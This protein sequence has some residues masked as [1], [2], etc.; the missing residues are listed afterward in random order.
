MSDRLSRRRFLGTV[1]ATGAGAA[2][3]ATAKAAPS[4]PPAGTGRQRVQKI[5]T[6][7]E[8]CFWRCGVLASV[9]RR[10]GRPA[11]GQPR[12]PAHPGAALRPRQRG[13]EPALRPRPARSTR[14][15][16]P[17]S[18][19]RASSSA[20]AGTRRSTSSPTSSTAHQGGARPRGGG[21]LPARH[22][23]PLLRHPDEGLRHAQQRRALVRAVPRPARRRLH[24]HLR[25][26][27]RLARAARPRRVE[28]HRP[29]RQPPRRE[30][31]HLADHAV[32]R[33]PRRA[34]RS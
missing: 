28:A 33:R 30:R 31:L 23:L 11:R 29:H 27:S 22:R 14:C 8:M 3:A 4:V 9:R 13:H 34:A 2:A 5:A 1:A 16:A 6:N 26:R 17:A 24:A 21:L 7:C 20:S 25:P 12:P 19:A 10:P 18:A 32:R 15:C